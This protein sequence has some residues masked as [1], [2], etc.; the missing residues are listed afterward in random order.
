[1]L[2]SIIFQQENVEISRYLTI[3]AFKW[4]FCY[5]KMGGLAFAQV[6]FASAIKKPKN[7]VFI[8][9]CARLAPLWLSP[10]LGFASAKQN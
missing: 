10:K 9:Y 3:G 8:F 4:L 7:Y 5:R 2:C 1:M 6:S